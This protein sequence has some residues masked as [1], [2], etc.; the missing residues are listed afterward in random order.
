[1]ARSLA[2]FEETFTE[3]LDSARRHDRQ[4]GQ[5]VMGSGLALSA[6]IV[7]WLLRG[8]ALAASLFSILPA[9]VSFDPIPILIA[10]RA[11]ARPRPGNDSSEAAVAR[12]LRSDVRHPSS[13]RS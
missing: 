3:L 7:A 6:G 12:V 10:Q 8:G 11:P 4:V 9:W 13:G 2:V 5:V 1:V